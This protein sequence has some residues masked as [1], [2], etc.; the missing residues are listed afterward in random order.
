M[1]PRKPLASPTFSA[2]AGAEAT[3]E[4]LDSRPRTLL[5]ADL[6][7]AKRWLATR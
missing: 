6:A 4:L 3:V 1:N 7:L 5:P 2:S